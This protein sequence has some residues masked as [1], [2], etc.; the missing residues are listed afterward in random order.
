MRQAGRIAAICMALVLALAARAD[1]FWKVKPPS[2]WTA[3]EALQLLSKSPW[4]RQEPV[5]TQSENCTPDGYD[6]YGNCRDTRFQLP[7][8]PGGRRAREIPDTQFNVTVYLVRWDSAPQVVAAFARLEELG[9][10][11]SAMFRSPPPRR[12][13][14]RYVI[15]LNV[16][17]P[18]RG[19]GDLLALSEDSKEIRPVRLKTSRG[20]FIPLETERS[21]VG[22]NEALHFFFPREHDGRPILDPRGDTAEFFFEGQ[23]TSFKCKFSLEAE[24]LR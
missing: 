18:A 12:P 15:T 17:Q 19:A 2:Q 23:R 21:G 9:Q 5:A 7:R 11:A 24:S 14:D 16:L 22:A 6:E 4:S 10:R 13:A 8:S 20:K 3:D 1:D